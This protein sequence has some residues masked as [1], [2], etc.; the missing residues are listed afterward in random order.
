MIGRKRRTALDIVRAMTERIVETCSPLQVIL[1]GSHARGDAGP[2]SDV[3]LLVV[4]PDT[5]DKQQVWDDARQVLRDLPVHADVVVATLDQ[6]RRYGNLVGMV[7]R[8]ALRDGRVLYDAGH[9]MHI[10]C[11]EVGR[12][13]RMPMGGPVTDE[14]RLAETRR[15]LRMAHE[16]LTTAEHLAADTDVAPRQ[17]CFFAQQAAEKAF[18]AILIFLQTEFPVTHSLDRL[19]ELTPTD[20]QAV[21]GHPNLQWLSNWAV[22]GRYP[23]PWPDPTE[24]DA[25]MAVEQARALCESARRDLQEHNLEIGTEPASDAGTPGDAD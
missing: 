25:Q 16:D 4:V 24:A 14:V 19:R 20:W 18:K 21:R 10:P 11:E 2:Q 7:F 15:W 9:G 1:F 13:A 22:R 3:D 5:A 23:G 8:P 17:A 12:C 6:I